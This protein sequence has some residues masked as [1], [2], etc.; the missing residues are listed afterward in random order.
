MKVSKPRVLVPQTA[1]L[2]LHCVGA[3]SCIRHN[4]E[5][6]CKPRTRRCLQPHPS[7]PSNQSIVYQP[8][9]Y[10]DLVWSPLA[11]RTCFLRETILV[12]Q[13]RQNIRCCERRDRRRVR[14]TL[15]HFYM[16]TLGLVG[17][18]K[19]RLGQ[20]TLTN[21]LPQSSCS[22]KRDSAQVRRA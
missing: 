15:S 10:C 19:W 1:A 12:R 7:P 17:R 3:Q 5:Q 16:P 11:Y 20:G 14:Q 21:C 22:H 6:A 18:G 8:F 2:L 9:D 4:I 13:T